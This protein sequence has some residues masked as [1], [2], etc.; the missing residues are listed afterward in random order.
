MFLKVLAVVL[1]AFVTLSGFPGGIV[2][3]QV[4]AGKC[5]ISLRRGEGT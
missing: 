5:E 2:A 1:S 3:E 4:C